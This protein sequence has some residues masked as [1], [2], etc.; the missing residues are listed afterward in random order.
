MAKPRETGFVECPIGTWEELV[1]R[2]RSLKARWVFRGQLDCEPLKSTLDREYGRCGIPLDESAIMSRKE[3]EN[4]LKAMIEKELMRDFQRLYDGPDRDRVERDILYCLAMMQHYGAPTRLMDWTYSPFV[5]AYFA[6]QSAHDRSSE[7]G[8]KDAYGAVWCLNEGWCRKGAEASVGLDLIA[9]REKCRSN[10]TFTAL[11]MRENGMVFRMVYLE[12][13][14]GLHARLTRQQGVFL[15]P[16]DVS[17][18]CE[19]NLRA[20]EGWNNGADVLVIRC[21]MGRTERLHALEELHRMNIDRSVL[22]PGLDGL[23]QSMKYR[24][25]FYR[26][27]AEWRKKF[28]VHAYSQAEG[29]AGN[30][31]SCC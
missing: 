9:L 31:R 19:E 18:T 13:P 25:R 21:K 5:A 2:L 20:M 15:C 6:L 30:R 3:T 17:L 16:G 8:E 22:F 26:E 14:F 27:Q 10:E 24:L 23:A 12:N 7:D 1:D 11:Y 29:N 28:E 4:M